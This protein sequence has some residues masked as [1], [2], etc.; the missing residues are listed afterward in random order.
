MQNF[1]VIVLSVWEPTDKIS[2][3]HDLPLMKKLKSILSN[4]RHCLKQAFQGRTLLK[5]NQQPVSKIRLVSQKQPHN[6][7]PFSLPFS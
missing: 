1:Q 3:L 4:N 6:L 2:H 5:V 7:F